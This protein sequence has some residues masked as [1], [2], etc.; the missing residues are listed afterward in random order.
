MKYNLYIK[1]DIYAALN[2]AFYFRCSNLLNIY[3]FYKT[4]G[5]TSQ[6]GLKSNKWCN[7]KKPNF[8]PW[9]KKNC[10]LKKNFQRS[11]PKKA[12][13]KKKRKKNVDFCLWGNHLLPS[14]FI[15]LLNYFPFLAH[16]ASALFWMCVCAIMGKNPIVT[17]T[18]RTRIF[19]SW[20]NPTDQHNF[21]RWVCFMFC[22]MEMKFWNWG[23][24]CKDNCENI[25]AFFGKKLEFM[26][27]NC[28]F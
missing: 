19:F 22:Y 7:L 20:N 27:S 8:F 5:I 4:L 24:N 3:D 16:C 25:A 15:Y 1:I 6:S 28:N 11:F 12:C 13:M 17:L 18:E 23:K 26:L 2:V 14:S 10:F 21:Y 9:R